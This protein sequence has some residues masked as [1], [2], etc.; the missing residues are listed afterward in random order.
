[1]VFNLVQAVTMNANVW[2]VAGHVV[3]QAYDLLC[4]MDCGD[5]SVDM[6]GDGGILHDG[7]ILPHVGGYLPLIEQAYEKSFSLLCFCLLLM[8]TVC[9][10]YF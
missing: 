7:T 8:Y 4:V 2:S 5:I 6:A 3:N 9:V 10:S 1:M